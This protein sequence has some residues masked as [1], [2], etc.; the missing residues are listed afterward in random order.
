VNKEKKKDKYYRLYFSLLSAAPRHRTRLSLPS[1][2]PYT[3][4]TASHHRHFSPEDGDSTFLRYV[5]IYQRVYTAPK[6]RISSSSS[7]PR[8]PQILIHDVG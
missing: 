6:H 8:E 2:L 1:L 5:G 4:S 7:L 3:K